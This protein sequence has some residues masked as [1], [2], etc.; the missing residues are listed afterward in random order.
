[1]CLKPKSVKINKQLRKIELF[2]STQKLTMIN[3]S[4]MQ[5]G[6]KP[7]N[8]KSDYVTLDQFF[9][10]KL[11]SNSQIDFKFEKFDYFTLCQKKYKKYAFS[12]HPNFSLKKCRKNCR[13]I[14]Y[15]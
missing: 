8:E 3:F 4:G 1:M 7:T 2:L 14:G 9:G 15:F 13:N 5:I 10:L 6:E 12:N 11:G